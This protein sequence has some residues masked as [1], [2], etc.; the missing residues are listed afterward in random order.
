ML[1]PLRLLPHPP[2]D[3][4]QPRRAIQNLNLVDRGPS[5]VPRTTPHRSTKPPP[6][7]ATRS[8]C[9]RVCV[10]MVVV[11]TWNLTHISVD[12]R[13]LM[14]LIKVAERLGVKLVPATREP[15]MTKNSSSS[16]SHLALNS[17]ITRRSAKKI[18]KSSKK[19]SSPP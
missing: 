10:V 19:P 5:G 16:R 17:G 6:P 18:F 4:L 8:A 13:Q 9:V 15:S 1:P 11:R 7:L 12:T 2:T 3:G 14:Q